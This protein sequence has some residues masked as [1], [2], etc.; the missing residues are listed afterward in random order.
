MNKTELS[1]KRIRQWNGLTQEEMAMRLGIAKSTYS[2]KEQGFIG[3]TLKDIA[4]VKREFGINI[5]E[6]QEIKEM[7]TKP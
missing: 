2:Q 5:D 4:N 7:A 3:W 6:L 1:I